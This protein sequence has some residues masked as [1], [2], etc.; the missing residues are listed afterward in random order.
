MRV[1]RVTKLSQSFSITEGMRILGCSTISVLPSRLRK[2]GARSLGR[3]RSKV[4]EKINLGKEGSVSALG[5]VSPFHH[6]TLTDCNAR[7]ILGLAIASNT[8]LTLASS[9]YLLRSLITRPYIHQF[10]H[11]LVLII[12]F[13]FI[14]CWRSAIAI[15]YLT[16]A[17]LPCASATPRPIQPAGFMQVLS[18]VPLLYTND[19]C[20]STSRVLKQDIFLHKVSA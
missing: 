15:P 1:E 11:H 16:F 20:P 19:C 17:S 13:I 7:C 14:S 18:C 10:L 6:P 12:C 3:D 2:D 9:R 4:C 8:S 5:T